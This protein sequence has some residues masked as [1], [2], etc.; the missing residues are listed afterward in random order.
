MTRTAENM[1]ATDVLREY[2]ANDV[3]LTRGLW[4][5][6]RLGKIYERVRLPYWLSGY[7]QASA[8]FYSAIHGNEAKVSLRA[9]LPCAKTGVPSMQEG[10]QWLVHDAMTDAEI[11]RTLLLATE[12]FVKHELYENFTVD[13]RRV[14]DPHKELS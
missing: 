8:G 9:W 12:A 7:G 1:T 4:F 2:C 6:D 14:F 10:R 3:K 13:G 5:L 11:I